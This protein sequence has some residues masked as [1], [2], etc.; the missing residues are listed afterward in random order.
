MNVPPSV[1]GQSAPECGGG[2]DPLNPK[3]GINLILLPSS[4]GTAIRKT[5]LQSVMS[6]STQSV[7]SG[8]Q[9]LINL[10]FLNDDIAFK[11]TQ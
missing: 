5:R 8:S 9:F 4:Y 2:S 11:R 3:T 1:Y 6:C 10:Q 7:A